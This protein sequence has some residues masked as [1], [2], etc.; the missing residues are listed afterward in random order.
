[1]TTEP[2]RPSTDGNGSARPPTLR[3]FTEPNRRGR[4][5]SSGSLRCD[6]CHHNVARIRVRWPDGSICGACFTAATHTYG[7]C[8]HCHTHRMTPGRSRAGEPICCDCARITTNL[9][10]DR[11]GRE[12]ERHRRGLCARCALDDDLDELLQP[13]TDRQ[14]RLLV[15]AL[16]S[17]DR[18]ESII[19][20]LRGRRAN[21]LLARI[22]NR[23][24]ALTHEALDALP[25]STAAEHIRALLIHH[26]ALPRRGSEPV[27]RFRLWL[28]ARLA[29]LPDD[30]TRSSIEQFA[31]WRHLRRIRDKEKHANAV[32]LDTVTHAAKQEITE[33]GKFLV[34][35]RTAYNV[36][37]AGIQ[38]AHVDE[39]FSEGATTRKHI[40][41]YLH[42]LQ[43]GKS[44]RQ[45]TVDAPHRVAKSLP[46]VTQDQRLEMVRN[47]I[48]L[49][50]VV[51]STRIAGLIF[52][53]WAQPLNRIVMLQQRHALRRVDGL[54]LQ[55]GKTPTIVPEE[56]AATFGTY[57]A[58]PDNQ[59]TGNTG[60][61]WLF[62]GRKAGGHL[63]EAT[64]G[65]RLKVLGIDPQ[66]ARNATL[67]D[68]TRQVDAR[69]L[70][71]LLGYS[72]Q[73][74]TLHAGR[75]GAPMADYVTLRARATGG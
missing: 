38:Q 3:T 14:L 18:P 11:C 7:A 5:R 65:Q 22:G 9:T 10:C 74:I 6:R 73:T 56:L 36:G 46:M 34:W 55:L 61:D 49:E 31:T 12:A 1:M 71:D 48:E 58:S 23:Q 52:L 28:T 8:A 51:A 67:Q 41:N 20:Y 70:I 25:R 16:A 15:N 68:L 43:R 63:H 66:R 32:N 62:P 45:R 60:T 72:G 37:P 19:S 35:L 64:L 59:R 29:Q 17:A 26:G 54:Y 33:A 47:C 44:H 2:G 13:G 69:S 57:F 42:W 40:R 39:Y 4:P 75:A 24:L 30:G 21:D 27:A 53:L 50:Q